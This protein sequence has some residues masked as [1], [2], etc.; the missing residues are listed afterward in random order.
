MFSRPN[1]A[2]VLAYRLPL[3]L[4]EQDALSWKPASTNQ[5]RIQSAKLTEDSMRAMLV[6][7]IPA[8]VL[9]TIHLADAQQPKVKVARLGYL[10]ATFTRSSPQTQVF[11]DE[12]RKLGYFEGQNLSV[13]F[14]NAEGKVDRLPELAAEILR[15]QVD[16]VVA[17][18]PEALL[19]AFSQATRNIPIV[20]IAIDYDPIELGYIS[21]LARPGG[22]ITGIFFRQL[23]LTSKRVEL[24]K[25]AFPET[26]RIA[27]FWDVFSADQVTD[28]KMAAKA[29]GSQTQWLQLGNPS[30]EIENAFQTARQ[31]R[32]NALLVLMSPVFL[33]E[34]TRITGQ[35]VKKRLP[36]MFGIREFPEAGGLMSYG[37]NLSDMF[38]RA[39]TYVDKIL[40]GTK[41]VNLPVEQ[42]LKFEFVINLEAAKQIGVTIPQSVLFRADKV[43]R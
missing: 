24:L 31:R 27:I 4:K 9:A 16:V 37:V 14:R 13:E 23:E 12:L 26:S 15:A 1:L 34:A 20:M 3:E 33:R 40:K 32:A 30:Y 11:F 28:A 39:A 5:R 6:Y 18:G 41:P 21:E 17:P 42:P 10:S 2:P 22:N 19:R 36:A 35:A 29:F 43:I 8:L 38:R 7:S 25:E